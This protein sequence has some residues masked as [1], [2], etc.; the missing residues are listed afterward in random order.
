L[1]FLYSKPLSKSM[2]R[3][4][5]T[6][7]GRRW[8]EEATRHPSSN[9]LPFA[10]HHPRTITATRPTS[11]YERYLYLVVSQG[12][13]NP[14]VYIISRHRPLKRSR[15]SF[16]AEAWRHSERERRHDWD[17]TNSPCN[18]RDSAS[19]AVA[20]FGCV[21]VRASGERFS[22]RESRQVVEMRHC[23]HKRGRYLFRNLQY[24]QRTA[25]KQSLKKGLQQAK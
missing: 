23:C 25:A 3:K 20:M 2:C 15:R 5:L 9:S 11:R 17:T 24:S 13:S 6:R 22:Q 19:S 10:E 4:T 16:R 21:Q 12:A 1:H 18:P 7:A 8:Q 14:M